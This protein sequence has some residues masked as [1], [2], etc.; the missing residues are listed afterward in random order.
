MQRLEWGLPEVGRVGRKWIMVRG[1]HISVIQDEWVFQV[2]WTA[3]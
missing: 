1:Y 2:Q 3:W